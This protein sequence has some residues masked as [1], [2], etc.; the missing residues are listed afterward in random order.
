MQA[1]GSGVASMVSRAGKPL[2]RTRLAGKGFSGATA[3][4]SGA[5]A[6]TH[7]RL[8]HAAVDS[9]RNSDARRGPRG[10]MS[11]QRLMFEQFARSSICRRN[12]ERCV[13]I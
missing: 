2:P 7:T 5:G 4:R 11:V 12:W 9:D 8:R 6:L 3:R 10:S 1:W 13:H